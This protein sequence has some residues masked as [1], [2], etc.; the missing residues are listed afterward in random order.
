MNVAG[1]D[2]RVEER[3]RVWVR[4]FAKVNRRIVI[5]AVVAVLATAMLGVQLASVSREGGPAPTTMPASACALT[6]ASVA[7][8]RSGT[9]LLPGDV[10][11]LDRMTP[12]ERVLAT[13]DS[14]AAGDSFSMSVLRSGRTIRLAATVVS[15][16]PASY[17]A[18]SLAI[19][20]V[21]LLAGI[22][23]LWRGRDAASL[24]YGIAS[25]FF[26]IAILPICDAALSPAGRNVYEAL[27][28]I[29][30]GISAYALYL[31]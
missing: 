2:K 7:Y 18:P 28:Q 11:L 17:W 16:V 10:L 26:A 3:R 22:F 6:I 19:K 8:A 9:Q 1:R 4:E 13:H 5:A 24:H 14:S 27:A 30:A 23:V 12:A 21:M 31:T 15:R 29:F 20:L 25:A